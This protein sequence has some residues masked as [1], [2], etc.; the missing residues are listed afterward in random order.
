MKK[1]LLNYVNYNLW[2]NT[3]LCRIIENLEPELWNRE[4]ISSYK[5]IRLTLLHIWDAEQIWYLR[6]N[7]NSVYEWPSTGFA[8]TNEELIKLHLS[9]S[10]LFIEYTDNSAED[11]FSSRCNFN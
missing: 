2:A 9:Q 11:L 1:L 6:L 10:E 3:R 4:L 5:T 7:G 8:G